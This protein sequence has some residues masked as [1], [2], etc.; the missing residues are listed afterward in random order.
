MWLLEVLERLPAQDEPG[1]VARV[2]ELRHAFLVEGLGDDA[3]AI[4]LGAVAD[5][6]RVVAGAA[7]AGAFAEHAQEVALATRDLDDVLPGEGVAFGELGREGVR[8]FLEARRVV[9]RVLVLAAVD[10]LRL[11]ERCVEDVRALATDHEHHVAAGGRAR[12]VRGVVQHVAEDGHRVDFQEDFGLGAP[13]GEAR[14]VGS[15]HVRR[16]RA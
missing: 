1:H 14:V 4:V 15:R 16:L 12:L 11:V 2:A 6:A 8:V 3:H 10:H 13:A 7:G 5:V 9:Q